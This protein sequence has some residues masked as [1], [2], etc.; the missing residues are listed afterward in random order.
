MSKRCHGEWLSIESLKEAASSAAER[1]S[2]DVLEQNSQ[3]AHMLGDEQ[4]QTYISQ[5][6]R[7]DQDLSMNDNDRAGH[8]RFINDQLFSRLSMIHE[9]LYASSQAGFVRFVA[10]G[11]SQPLDMVRDQIENYKLHFPTAAKEQK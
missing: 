7:I 5:R 9:M 8:C 11:L 6:R 4:I 10:N 3:Q 2:K 1:H